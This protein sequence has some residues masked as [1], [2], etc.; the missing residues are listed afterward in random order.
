MQLLVKEYRWTCENS[1]KVL[2]HSEAD[3]VKVFSLVL[4]IDEGIEMETG[5]SAASSNSDAS[6]VSSEAATND[7]NA[8]ELASKVIISCT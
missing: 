3:L 4:A 5:G 6:S 8:R 2:C 1:S 7:R